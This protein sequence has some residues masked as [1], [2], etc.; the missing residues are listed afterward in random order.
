M[1]S[2]DGKGEVVLNLSPRRS[3]QRIKSGRLFC[4]LIQGSSS[5]NI[6]SAIVVSYGLRLR[7]GHCCSRALH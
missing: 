4:V 6:V 1:P 5:W 7:I 2:V 3:D